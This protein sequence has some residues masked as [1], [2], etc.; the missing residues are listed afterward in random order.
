VHRHDRAGPRR[1]RVR[2]RGRIERPHRRIDVRE[3]GHRAGGLDTGDGRD[4]RRRRDHDLV[5]RLDPGG[6]QRDR[7]RVRSRRDADRLAGAAERREL[8]LEV[9]DSRPEHKPPAVEHGRDRRV[10]HRALR[11]DLARKVEKRHVHG[12]PQYASPNSA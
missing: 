5:A 7:D 8:A 1:D 3:H 12:S 11:R 6:P 4:A 10:D 2:G 9:G